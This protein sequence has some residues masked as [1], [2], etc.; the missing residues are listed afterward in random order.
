[1]K[2]LLVLFLL[3]ILKN[4][5]GH[6]AALAIDEF[7]TE[8]PWTHIEYGAGNRYKNYTLTQE[9]YGILFKTLERLV[10]EYGPWGIFY[11]NDVDNESARVAAFFLKRFAIQNGWED[12]Q[13]Q[14]LVGDIMTIN[15]PR[16]DT[17]H[18]KNPPLL[19]MAGL[20]FCGGILGEPVWQ[21]LANSSRTGLEITTYFIE[22][23]MRA[24]VEYNFQYLDLGEGAPYVFPDGETV[25]DPTTRFLIK[26]KVS[27]YLPHIPEWQEDAGLCAR[28]FQP[29]N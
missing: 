7:S 10:E 20:N 29:S 11:V 12:I 13:V 27:V 1:M 21:K 3:I 25:D 19:V 6:T 8:H 9:G 22:D 16:T 15:P 28:I 17:A 18:F 5:V 23:F 14:V 26:P 2:H 4:G 24:S